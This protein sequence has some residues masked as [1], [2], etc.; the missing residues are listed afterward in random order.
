MKAILLAGGSGSR[1]HP[2]TQVVNKQLMPIYDKP[3]VY[4]PLSVLMLSGIRDILIISTEQDLPKFEWLFGDGSDLGLSIEYVVQKR[5]EG[6]AQAFLLAEEFLAGEDACLILGDN[7]FYGHGISEL[8]TSSVEDVKATR[9]ATVFGYYVRDPERYGVAEF[10]EFGQVS[11]IEEKPDN[12]S[13]NFAVV[14]LYFYPG[15]VVEIAKEVI[16][17]PRGELEISSVNQ[18]YLDKQQLQLKIIGRGVAWLDTGT[19]ESLL[20]A[21][22][23]IQTIEKRQGLKVACLEE[24]AFDKG[25][26]D[27]QQLL[28]LA[29][30]MGSS[31]YGDYLTQRAR[32]DGF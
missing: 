22:N 20:E 19:H 25:Y 24:I 11:K 12:P 26:I 8:L 2:I 30:K 15:N 32:G 31:P 9:K 5:P 16:P 7:I 27:K 1:L 17:S 10:D 28:K 21:A 14:G 13:S 4:Y 29:E 18:A 3:M 6:I 23:F